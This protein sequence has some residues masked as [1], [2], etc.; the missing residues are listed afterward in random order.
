MSRDIEVTGSGYG[1]YTLVKLF[2][3]NWLTYLL[4][5]HLLICLFNYVFAHP[6]TPSYIFFV[7]NVS[8]LHMFNGI[9]IVHWYGIIKY[10]KVGF[11][12]EVTSLIMIDRMNTLG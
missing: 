4:P 9:D 8:R 7:M 11:T 6:M 3:T 2:I 10:N 1:L 12:S 5:V